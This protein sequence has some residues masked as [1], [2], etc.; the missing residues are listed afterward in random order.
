M[1]KYLLSNESE[2]LTILKCLVEKVC[3]LQKL[4]VLL[5]KLACI[6]SKST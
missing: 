2:H 6:A 3:K 1:S 4:K 5:S